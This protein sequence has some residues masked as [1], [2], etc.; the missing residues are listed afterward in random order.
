MTDGRQ[1]ALYDTAGKRLDGA[2]P[3]TADP[4]VTD[5]LHGTL[6]EG[7]VD[8]D[9]VAA[10]PVPESTAAAGDVVR[11]LE[12]QSVSGAR[13]RHALALLGSEATLACWPP[14]PSVRSS[15][16]G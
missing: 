15:P 8:G 3:R 2:G 11:L 16:A 13:I 1:L 5:A 6:T 14:R 7:Y 9:L 10:A 4:V 12:P